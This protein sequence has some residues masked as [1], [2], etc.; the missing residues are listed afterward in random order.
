MNRLLDVIAKGVEDVIVT[1]TCDFDL[2]RRKTSA[3]KTPVALS[4]V[5]VR[6]SANNLF[7]HNNGLDLEI[8]TV[9]SVEYR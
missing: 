9:I 2:A 1:E 6:K 3:G 4:L 7:R 5:E 8:F